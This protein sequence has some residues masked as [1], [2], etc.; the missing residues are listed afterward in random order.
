VRQFKYSLLEIIWPTEVQ[1][2]LLAVP[3][4]D[5]IS[6]NEYKYLFWG[7]LI[8]GMVVLITIYEKVK[9]T[10]TVDEI[11]VEKEQV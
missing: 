11:V 3:E 9:N 10:R 5:F 4:D 2:T 8:L 6:S 1:L 7:G